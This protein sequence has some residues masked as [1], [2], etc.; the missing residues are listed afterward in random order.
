[1]IGILKKI[2]S[3]KSVDYRELVNNGAVIVDVR[4]PGE[5]KSGHINSSKNYP[6]DTIRAKVNE[7]KKL[8]KPVITVCRSGARSGVAKGILKSAGIE[9]YNGGPWNSL[10]NKVGK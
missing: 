7:L 5:Y 6:L 1:M 3:N 10:K 2:F 4:T 8:N 9:A